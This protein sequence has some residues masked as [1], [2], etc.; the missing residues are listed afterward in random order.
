VE[1]IYRA[2]GW[3]VFHDSD[4]RRNEEGYPDLVAVPPLWFTLQFGRIKPQYIELKTDGAG[5]RKIRRSGAIACKRPIRTDRYVG[6]ATYSKSA[7]RADST[8]CRKLAAP[9]SGGQS[10]YC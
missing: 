10:T 1:Q 9:A 2:A 6:R 4:S 7:R 5:C 8:T 3:Q